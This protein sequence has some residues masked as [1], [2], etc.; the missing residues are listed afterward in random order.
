[1][2]T[3]AKLAA[4]AMG[5]R[6]LENNEGYELRESQGSYNHV[7]TPEKCSLSLKNNHFWQV[8]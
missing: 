4:K 1:M 8:Y 2:K 6:V 5:R 3:N 7:F